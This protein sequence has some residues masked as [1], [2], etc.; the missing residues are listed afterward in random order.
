M[1]LPAG[2]L[3]GPHTVVIKSLI[4]IKIGS[5]SCRGCFRMRELCSARTLLVVVVVGGGLGF[6]KWRSHVSAAPG[7]S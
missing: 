5:E 4:S 7:V 6:A 2:N 1:F 3:L